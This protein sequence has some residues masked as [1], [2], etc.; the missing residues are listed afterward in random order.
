MHL[1]IIH[2]SKTGGLLGSLKALVRV[3][4]RR[5]IPR[6]ELILYALLRQ[7]NNNN[8][9]PLDICRYGIHDETEKRFA[10]DLLQHYT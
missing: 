10:L 3:I 6:G 2:R 1:V 5:T 8:R 4:A 9:T 7:R